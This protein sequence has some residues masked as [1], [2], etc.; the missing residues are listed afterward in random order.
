M[1]NTGMESEMDP[2]GLERGYNFENNGGL[3]FG[4]VSPQSKDSVLNPESPE[5][6]G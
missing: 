4:I 3:D 5:W 2:E 1:A 6:E